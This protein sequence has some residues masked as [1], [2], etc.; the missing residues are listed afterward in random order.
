MCPHTASDEF[1]LAADRARRE[2]RHAAAC[3]L[4]L[5]HRC[6]HTASEELLAA[7]RARI[8]KT[9]CYICV[10]MLLYICFLIRHTA[11]YVLSYYYC[12]DSAEPT[13]PA[14]D[15]HIL[16]YICRLYTTIYVSACY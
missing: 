5:L 12:K 2:L 3:V 9:Y 13:P 1:P 10:L 7:D 15:Y 14:P 6:P 8:A 16:L 4:I 11:I